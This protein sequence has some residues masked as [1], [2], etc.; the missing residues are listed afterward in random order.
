MQPFIY[1]SQPLLYLVGSDDSRWKF[2]CK[3]V[4][5]NI[6]VMYH[7]KITMVCTRKYGDNKK[8]PLLEGSE[9]NLALDSGLDR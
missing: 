2:I 9:A 3:G 1:G 7:K 4:E 5:T 6:R 8:S